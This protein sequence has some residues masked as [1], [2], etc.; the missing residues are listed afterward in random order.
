MSFTS[1]VLCFPFLCNFVYFF[2]DFCVIL[3]II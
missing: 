2:I 3:C 1:I